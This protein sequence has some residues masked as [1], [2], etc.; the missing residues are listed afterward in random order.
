MLDQCRGVAAGKM[1]RVID[2]ALAESDSSLSLEIDRLVALGEVNDHVSE[3]EINDLRQQQDDLHQ[4]ISK[5]R[6]R[7]D[8]V[9]VIWCQP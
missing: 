8:A 2:A 6:L 1:Q 5:A 3:K 9:R 7:F 4:V